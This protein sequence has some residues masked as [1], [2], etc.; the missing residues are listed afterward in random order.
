MAQ[1]SE[2][3]PAHSA[4]TGA[5]AKLALSLLALGV[6]FGDIGTSPLYAIAESLSPHHG[7][8]RDA[9]TVLGVLSL[10]FWSLTLV[11]TVKYAWFVLSADNRGEGGIFSLLS[12]LPERGKGLRSLPTTFFVM[13][14]VGAAVL[15]A[16]GVLTPSLSV[17]SAVEGLQ[18]VS[19]ELKQFVIPSTCLIL[20]ALFSVQRLGT[21]KLGSALGPMMLAWF[22]VIGV[23]GVRGIM[24]EP[25]VLEALNPMQ[26]LMLAQH[27]PWECFVALGSVM[28]CI[29]GGE[30]LYADLGHFGTFPIRAAWYGIVMPGLLLNYMGQGAM[31]LQDMSTEQPFFR[32][33]PSWAL[34]PL[35]IFAT[36]ATCIAS[37]AILTGLFSLT[38]QAIQLGLL[39]RLRVVYTSDH[40]GHIFV[41]TVNLM[42]MIAC[43]LIVM[44]FEESRALAD[45]YG[46]SVS[47]LML[48]TTI[49]FTV[50]K[51]RTSWG[52]LRCTVFVVGLGAIDL[53][54]LSANMLKIP[55][56]GWLTLTIAAV[57]LV[58]MWTWHRGRQVLSARFAKQVLSF[59]ALL[60]SLDSHP[61]PRVAGTAIFLTPSDDGVPPTLLHHLK[62]NKVLHEHVAIMSVRTASVPQVPEDE[63]VEVHELRDG[64]YRVRCTHGFNQPVDVP[65]FT[66]LAAQQGLESREGST[67]YYLGRT[68][69]TPRGNSDLA[70]WQKRLFCNMSQVSAN[71]PLYFS[72]PPGRMVELG[73]QIDL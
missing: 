63:Q 51:W 45:A 39:P 53:L 8:P 31:Y 43:L 24:M 32:L 57:V 37:Q 66:R 46:L 9:A 7:M 15:Y 20:L 68:I 52:I 69:L 71:N 18:V 49:L 47:M 42:M 59:D 65:W 3:I 50:Y 25:R 22:A 33:A 28:L 36:L 21:A 5:T 6:V 54:F 60:N 12:L 40:Q 2:P 4:P 73:I 26:A 1:S 14:M 72:I 41:P 70:G 55:N 58:L 19:P 48:I 23:L 35:V 13:G 38:H 44:I 16:D 34:I 62:H 30:A 56:G 17:L 67:T 11:I 10:F 64:F 29:T 61:I 27:H